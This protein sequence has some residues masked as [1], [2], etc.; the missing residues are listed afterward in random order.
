[1]TKEA[2]L[3]GTA[4]LGCAMLDLFRER[5]NRVRRRG[6]IYQ[7]NNWRRWLLSLSLLLWALSYSGH[8]G[9]RTTAQRAGEGVTRARPCSDGNGSNR[10]QRTMRVQKERLEDRTVDGGAYCGRAGRVQV[11]VRRRRGR[12]CSRV[13]LCGGAWS[14]SGWAEFRETISAFEGLANQR[15]P[16]TSTMLEEVIR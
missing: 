8:G 4:C 11:V 1:M 3:G 13:W 7:S 2:R 10:R 12:G 5:K 15:P 9:F 6:Q 14:L 16:S